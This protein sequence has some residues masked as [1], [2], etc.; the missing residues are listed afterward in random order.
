MALINSEVITTEPITKVQEV[1]EEVDKCEGICSR[2]EVIMDVCLRYSLIGLGGI[3]TL[4]CLPILGIYC[5][6][7]A[8]NAWRL[9]LTS[10]AIHHQYRDNGCCLK[11]WEIP[12]SE[13]TRY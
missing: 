13:D 1:S 8:A 6:I 10:S 12:L 7:R 3:M 2:R 5:G 9:Y 4:V 11:T